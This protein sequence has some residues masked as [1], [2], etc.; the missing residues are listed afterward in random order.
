M[1]REKVAKSNVRIALNRMRQHKKRGGGAND[2][3]IGHL[4]GE[5]AMD[6]PSGAV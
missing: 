6:V 3:P 5:K 1:K 2:N 4:Y